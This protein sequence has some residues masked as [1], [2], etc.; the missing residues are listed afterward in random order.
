MLSITHRIDSGVKFYLIKQALGMT[1]LQMQMERP[2]T[3]LSPVAKVETL[4]DRRTFEQLLANLPP[5][6]R[7]GILRAMQA[8]MRVRR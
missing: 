8:R 6:R 4:D 2:F 1:G 3:P 7:E 5:S